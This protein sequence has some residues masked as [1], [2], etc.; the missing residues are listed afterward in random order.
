MS[1]TISTKKITI[2]GLI[3]NVPPVGH[4]KIFNTSKVY[5]D[6]KTHSLKPFWIFLFDKM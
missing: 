3:G 6:D 2:S 1:L 4:N 5:Y